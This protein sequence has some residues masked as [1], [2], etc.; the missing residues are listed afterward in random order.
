MK[1]LLRVLTLTFALVAFPGLSGAQT[2]FAGGDLPAPLNN[3]VSDIQGMPAPQL[4]AIIG[5]GVIGGALADLVLDG[6]IITVVGVIV[7]AAVGNQWYVQRYW[8]F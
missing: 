8:P 4:G 3:V 6:G 2:L 7:G 1:N 5:G